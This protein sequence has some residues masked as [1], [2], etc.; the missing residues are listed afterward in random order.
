MFLVCS[1]QVYKTSSFFNIVQPEPVA[2]YFPPNSGDSWEKVSPA[3][4]GWNLSAIQPLKD[5]LAKKHSKSFLILVNGRIAIEDYFDGHNI[6]TTWQ[7]NSAGKTLISATIGIAQQ[8]HLLNIND[9][10]SQYLGYNWTNMPIEKENL[11]SVKNLLTMTSGTNNEKNLVTRRNLTY[12]ADAGNRWAYANVFQKL[13]NI[14]SNASHSE[15]ESFFNEKLKTKIG[16]EGYWNFGPIFSIYHSNTR[17]MARFGLLAL[18]NGKWNDQQIINESYFKE[19]I[20]SSQNINPA[21]GYLWWLN[22]KSKYM[23]PRSQLVYSGALIPN[24][25]ADLFAAMGAADQRIYVIPSKNMV[26]IRMGKASD[27]LHPNFAASGF[28]QELWDK[29]NAVIN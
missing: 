21:Y 22:G 6:K 19:S 20:Q 10:A 3:A 14:I 8:E 9:K 24:A 29:I 16:M 4:L 5:Y 15:F 11:I 12:V 25:P 27:P 17:S 13:T 28:D 26:V 2:M 7:W 1:T 18:N 23:I